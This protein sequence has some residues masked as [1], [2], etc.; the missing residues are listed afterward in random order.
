MKLQLS[1]ILL[2]A[3]TRAV[4][5]MHTEAR[6]RTI[7]RSLLQRMQTAQKLCTLGDS[8]AESHATLSISRQTLA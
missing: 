1:A 3:D 7:V 6:T 5:Y 8:G 4:V 2:H